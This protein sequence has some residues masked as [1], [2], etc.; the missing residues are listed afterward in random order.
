VA[1]ADL[2][3][4]Y[5]SPHAI[6]CNIVVED[7]L[8]LDQTVSAIVTGGA[9]G[10]GDATARALA[11]KGVRVAIFDLN[12]Q[13]GRAVAEEIGGTF[14]RADVTDAASVAAA[15]ERARA[16]HGQER[17][18]VNCAGGGTSA[19]IVRRNR[20]TGSVEPMALDRFTK[21]VHL[22][23]MSAFQCTAISAAGMAILDP[24]EGERGVVVNTASAAAQDGQV[25]QVAYAAAKAGIVG[26]TLPIAR[27]LSSEYIRVN[28]IMPGIFATPPMLAAP[29][30]MRVAL[31]KSVPFPSRLGAPNEYAS[32]VLEICRNAYLNGEV[33][34][35]DGA[36]RMPPR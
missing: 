36:I 1:A 26:M 4:E 9:S 25:G 29:E 16:A 18:M 15:F 7:D 12:E 22:N 2:G 17:I 28:T 14:C 32:L 5:R 24:I 19:K 34:R 20:E 3:L 33:I 35:L 23:L 30:E 10:L 6:A 11:G 13:Q 8:L 31:A 27:D 21:I